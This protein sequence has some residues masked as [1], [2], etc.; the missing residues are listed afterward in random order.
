[1]SEELVE[2]LRG[3]P[4]MMQTGLTQAFVG[5][6]R[7]VTS[8][9]QECDIVTQ[10]YPLHLMIKTPWG[11]VRF[12]MPFFVLSGGG[13]VLIIGQKTLTEK[14]GTNFMTSSRHRC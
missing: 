2:D 9:G 10:S 12:T 7:V 1:M 6:A 4:A 11:P 3:Q 8:L 13:D 5:H 14:L